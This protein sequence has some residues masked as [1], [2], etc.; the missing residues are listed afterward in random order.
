MEGS[1]LRHLNEV[2]TL[3]D[4]SKYKEHVLISRDWPTGNNLHVSIYLNKNR[5]SQIVWNA[6]ASQH[7]HLFNT[8]Q[9]SK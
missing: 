2:V 1:E 6:Y 8:V 9:V 5:S 4:D 3:G 7:H